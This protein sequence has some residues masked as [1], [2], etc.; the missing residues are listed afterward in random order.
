MGKIKIAVIGSCVSRDGFNSKF[1]KDY[2][3]YYQCVLTQNHMSMISLVSE[4]TPFLPKKLGDK[5]TDFNKQILLTELTKGVWDSLK[6]Q[7]P[8]YLI[9]DFYA[10]V[11]FGI[12]YVDEKIITNKTPLF[13]KAP[14]YSTLNLGRSITLDN[15]YEEYMDLWKKS[16]DS[17]MEIM[18]RDFPHVKIIVNKMKFTD[19]YIPKEKSDLKKISESGLCRVVDVDRINEWLD[20]FYQY[21][22]KFSNISFLEYN[23]EYYSVEGHIWDI[24]YVH[25][26]NDFYED[27][28]TKL[29]SVIL[30]DLYTARQK[31]ETKPQINKTHDNLLRNSTFN[32]GKAFWTLWQDD[33][34]IH[35]PEKDC[36]ASNILSIEHKGLKEDVFRQIWSHPIEINTDGRQD[37]TISFDIKVN[38]VNEVDSLKFVFSLRAFNNIDKVSQKDA[39]WYRNIKVE[40]IDHIKDGKWTRVSHTFKPERSK[41]LKVGPYLMRNGQISWRNIKLEKGN[42]ATEWTPSYKE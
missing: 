9:L 14:L 28:T 4:P 21:F 38:K 26:T 15:N 19:Y 20:G 12:I 41:F 23:K 36:P 13:K 2:K 29:L 8:D 27:F 37:Y 18:R 30:D 25:Y 33:F 32:M 10:D 22:E 6:I 42:Q 35:E 17:F 31:N 1:I 16:V 5:I 39:V 40:D 24:F 34:K 7:E 3:E 11:Y